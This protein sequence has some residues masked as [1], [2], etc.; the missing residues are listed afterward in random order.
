MCSQ[1]AMGMLLQTGLALTELTHADI[2]VLDEA[3]IAHSRL[4]S[5]AN[6]YQIRSRP[7]PR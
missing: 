2:A 5:L 4:S 7:R 1:V 3:I 6:A